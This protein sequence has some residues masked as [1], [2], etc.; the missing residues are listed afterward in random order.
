MRKVLIMYRKEQGHETAFYS[1]SA[2]VGHGPEK[3]KAGINPA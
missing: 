2:Q 3:E 1:D